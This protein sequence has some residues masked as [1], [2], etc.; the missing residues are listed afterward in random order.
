MAAV[1]CHQTK[2]SEARVFFVVIVGRRRRR[3]KEILSF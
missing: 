3:K 2:K 1:R